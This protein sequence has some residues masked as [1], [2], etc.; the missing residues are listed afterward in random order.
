MNIKAILQTN[1]VKLVDNIDGGAQ[2]AEICDHL[3]GTD[4]VILS[5]GMWNE[6]QVTVTNVTSAGH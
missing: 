6:I 5:D 1:R 4:P 2:L 3:K